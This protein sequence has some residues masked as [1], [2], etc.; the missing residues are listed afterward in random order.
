M[1]WLFVRS[2]MNDERCVA[3]D[4]FNKSIELDHKKTQALSKPR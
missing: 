3:M 1:K 2:N 4:D